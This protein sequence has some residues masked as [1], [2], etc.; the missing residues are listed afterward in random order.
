[1]ITPVKNV[2]F[3]NFSFSGV[4]EGGEFKVFKLNEI[5]YLV[6]KWVVFTDAKL[7]I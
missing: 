2:T 3:I 7:G 6:V 5:F 4:C 1:M